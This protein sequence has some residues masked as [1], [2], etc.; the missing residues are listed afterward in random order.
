MTNLKSRLEVSTV[1]A[2]FLVF[3]S[4]GTTASTIP[5]VIPS[6]ASEGF[7]GI[8]DYL[9]AVPSLFWGL[10]VGVLLSSAIGRV[11]SPRRVT[12]TGSAVQAAGFIVLTVS[13]APW[14]FVG[15]AFVIGVGFG[16]IEAGG[17]ILARA[18]GGEGTAR[19]L[20]A[21]TGTV[22]LVAAG[23]PLLIAMS[24]LEPAP[25]IT[26]IAVAVVHCLA[27]VLTFCTLEADLD[28]SESDAV[29]ART[30]ADLGRQPVRVG[31]VLI[32]IAGALSLYV[33]V[34]TVYAGWS[35]TIPLLVLDVS[36]QQAAIGTSLFWV[37]L[38]TGR[39]LATFL[40]ARSVSPSIYLLTSSV[41]A[42]LMLGLTALQVKESPLVATIA[43]CV[44]V[45]ALGPCYSLILSAGLS[46]IPLSRARWA[47]GLLVACGAAGGALVP[48]I[49]LA[50]TDSPTSTA[51]FA[52]TGGL[53]LAFGLLVALKTRQPDVTP[54][55]ANT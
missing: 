24:P 7:G 22:A 39:Y 35:S 6:L 5:A 4:M 50:S 38:A 19:L 30:Q 8:E 18:A 55:P 46:L 53:T 29:L 21:L 41:I 20:S 31:K 26:L 23:V 12:L 45:T 36:T 42:A 14:F 28:A 37:L 34:E 52:V 10:L 2:L 1:S 17:S 32:A 13:S 48:T 51:V 40:L 15:A 33:G 9:R 43:L 25:R 11:I 3:A 54:E 27:M 44:A 16:L 49:L 47:T